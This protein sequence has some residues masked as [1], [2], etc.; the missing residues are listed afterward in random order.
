MFEVGKKYKINPTSGYIYEVLYVG[1]YVT[2]V[3]S[4]H[5]DGSTSETTLSN[6]HFIKYAEFK[7]PIIVAGYLYLWKDGIVSF[8]KDKYNAS[9]ASFIS[10][11]KIKVEVTE[12]EFD[13]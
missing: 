4:H 1:E 11:K 8:S 12:G 10:R 2:L 3:K 6:Y 9:T 7:E 5:K 13:V